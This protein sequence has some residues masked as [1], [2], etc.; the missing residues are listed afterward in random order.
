MF[1]NEPILFAFPSLTDHREHTNAVAD[2]ISIQLQGF[3]QNEFL[4]DGIHLNEKGHK[5]LAEKLL[6]IIREQLNNGANRSN[7]DIHSFP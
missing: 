3:G 5:L 4:D 7:D 1:K 6:P 2:L